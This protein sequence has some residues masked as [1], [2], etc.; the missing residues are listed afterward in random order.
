MKKTWLLG[1][2]SFV[3]T[4]LLA[5]CA[6]NSPSNTKLNSTAVGPVQLGSAAYPENL[7]VV[8]TTLYFSA[9]DFNLGSTN[10]ELW[11]SDGTDAG[12]VLVKEIRP[13]NSGSSPE[14]LVDVNGTLFFRA[15]DGVN[16]KEL[17]K[18]DGTASGTVMVKNINPNGASSPYGMINVNGIV[19]F[20]ADN[21]VNG[22]ELW[23]SDGTAAGTVMVRNINPGVSG[24]DPY[25][26]TNIN[27]TIY[28]A[29]TT[30]GFG[31][32]LWKTNGTTT[33]TRRVKDINPTGDSNLG[34][35]INLNNTLFF[36]ANDG[37]SGRELWK[38][39]GTA[40]GTILVKD[41]NPGSGDTYPGSFTVLGS[42]LLFKATDTYD[43]NTGAANYEL[44]KSDGTAAGTTLVKDINPSGNGYSTPIGTANGTLFFQ[45]NDGVT[46]SELWK[47]NGTTTGTR[48]VKD[49]WKGAFSSN[50]AGGRGGVYLNN[51]LYFQA[52]TTT[53]GSELW[54]STGT[55]AG[56][57]LVSDVFPGTGGSRPGYFTNIN[58]TIFFVTG[59]GPGLFGTPTLWKYVP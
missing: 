5:G 3:V 4:L 18:S 39:D 38:S 15:D 58:G 8:G 26:F 45:A 27:G 37:V 50:P 11:K 29:A 13:G 28:F 17:W 30:P 33:G 35:F 10:Y 57:S 24:S 48:R 32:E 7:T 14:G 46:G 31:Y 41:I 55:A 19:Y 1:I 59:V 47:T 40:A 43:V 21:G 20:R 42:I 23:K 56:T 6:A 34:D 54:K 9:G 49:I 2:W 44:W 51:T 25:G 52:T 12:T 22:Y 36:I 16:G 53:Y